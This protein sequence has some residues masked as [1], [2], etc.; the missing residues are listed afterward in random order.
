MER[1]FQEANRLVC[2]WDGETLIVEPWGENGLRVRSAML[3]E[4]E[5][6][7]YAL[8]P[9]ER[10]EAVIMVGEERSEIRNGK[11]IGVMEKGKNS[12]AV[13]SFYNSEGK[14]LLAEAG[15][16]G[17]VHRG[18]PPPE[19]F[20]QAGHRRGLPAGCDFRIRSGGKAVWDGAVSAGF[21]EY[22]VLQ[23]GA[24]AEKFP[25]KRAFSAFQPGVWFSV[26]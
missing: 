8:L 18:G 6:T 4:P 14:L 11:I 12:G 3:R 15:G 23:P 19:P 22:Q 26:A 21:S 17:A 24:G 9:Q 1:M 16:G 13:L 5:D 20:F 2:R 10:A 7:D 25:G